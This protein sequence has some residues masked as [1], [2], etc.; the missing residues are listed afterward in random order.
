MIVIVNIELYPI[1]CKRSSIFYY[2]FH[3]VHDYMCSDRHKW[4][5]CIHGNRMVCCRHRPTGCRSATPLPTA[6][7]AVTVSTRHNLSQGFPYPD[8]L[9]FRNRL[10]GRVCGDPILLS[11]DFLNLLCHF[12]VSEAAI[13]YR[14]I[15]D[16]LIWVMTDLINLIPVFIVIRMGGF[17]LV[18]L[19][20]Q[21]FF[22][23]TVRIFSGINIF[24]RT[25]IAGR[26]D[27]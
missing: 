21:C 5:R 1:S 27:R 10:S 19:C 20:I 12:L 16:Q 23:G 6:D 8:R 22:Q 2:I 11:E 14:K 13:F 7:R 3:T 17:H 15:R 25:G 9:G 4:V 26:D 24:I 18:D